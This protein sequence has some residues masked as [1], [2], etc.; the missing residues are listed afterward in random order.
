MVVEHL[1]VGEEFP[2]GLIDTGIPG[3]TAA[4]L[5]VWKIRWEVRES[6]GL[7]ALGRGWADLPMPD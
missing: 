7:C 2:D 5:R 1:T 6:G 4:F 3:G